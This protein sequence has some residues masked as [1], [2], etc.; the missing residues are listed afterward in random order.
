MRSIK[1][2]FTRGFIEK[3]DDGKCYQVKTN[4]DTGQIV[5]SRPNDLPIPGGGF[6]M[7]SCTMDSG[8]FN[9]AASWGL[10]GY[11][12]AQPWKS[13]GFEVIKTESGRAS[14]VKDLNWLGNYWKVSAMVGTPQN[15]DLREVTDLSQL[16]SVKA[17]IQNQYNLGVHVYYQASILENYEP[18]R[19]TGKID[20]S[21][22]RQKT[23]TTNYPAL[24][25]KGLAV[26]ATVALIYFGTRTILNRL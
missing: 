19:G 5:D 25:L 12:I 10:G 26:L 8:T 13:N 16:E 20:I 18:E 11:G 1:A 9:S 3:R 23:P 17:E 22:A 4:V 14:I 15:Y 2:F 6:L 7:N 21:P 24:A